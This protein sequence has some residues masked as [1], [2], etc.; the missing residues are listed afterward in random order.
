MNNPTTAPRPSPE[1]DSVRWFREEVQPHEPALRA[2]LRRRY[3]T[4][5]DVDDFVQESFLK[6]CLE[7]RKRDLASPKGFLFRVACN[8][9]VSFFRK[10]SHIS[11]QPVN[12][13]EVLCV[14]EEDAD[15]FATVCSHDEIELISEAIAELPERCREIVLLRLMKGHDYSAIAQA[16]GISEPTVRVQVARGMRK[17]AAFLRERGIIDVEGER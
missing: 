11:P 8:A 7:R 16:L 14:Q 9:V 10:R 3:P 1:F 6:A 17:C 4:L 12:E 13:S 2:Y 15:V 5:S